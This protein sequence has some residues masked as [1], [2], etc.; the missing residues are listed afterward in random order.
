PLGDPKAGVSTDL[1]ALAAYVTSLNRFDD[2]PNRPSATTL[3][4]AATAGRTVFQDR[5]CQGC[6]G[7]SAFTRSG[8]L[9]AQNIG[10]IKASSG[11]R[12]GALLTGIDI[13]TLRDVGLTAPYLHDG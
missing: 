3:S 4:S 7:G 10:T 6:H 12:L 8:T 1:D 13:P 2:S 11:Q 5:N 9:A